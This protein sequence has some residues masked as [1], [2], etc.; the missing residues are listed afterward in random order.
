VG[1]L[2]AEILSPDK[3]YYEIVGFDLS[4]NNIE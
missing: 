1:E 4:G 3:V 2:S